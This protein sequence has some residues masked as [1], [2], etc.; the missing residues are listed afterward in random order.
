[1]GIFLNVCNVI[2]TLVVEKYTAK[3][4]QNYL[5][6]ALILLYFSAFDVHISVFGRIIFVIALFAQAYI[7]L[8]T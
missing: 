4:Q 3:G 6:K 1:M 2:K 8:S 7:L 5:H